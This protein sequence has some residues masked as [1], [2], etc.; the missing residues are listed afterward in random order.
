M[1]SAPVRYEPHEKPPHA[2]AAGLGAQ[3]VVLMVTGVMVTPL[4]IS[5][6]A[7]LDASTTGWLV[8]AALFA[9]G[10]STWLQTSRFGSVGGG[11]AL[12]VG[13]NVAFVSVCTSAIEGGGLPLMATLAMLS[14]FSCFLFTTQMGALRRVLTPAV[15]GMTLM[16]M[17]LSVAPVVWKLLKKVPPEFAD[18]NLP[19]MLAV[20]TLVPIVLI[21]LFAGDLL[22]LWAPLVGVAV[23]SAVAWHL[24]MIDPTAVLAAPWIGMP[25]A[26][27]P[28]LDLSFGPE[29][30]ALLPAFVLISLVGCIE[31]YA[32]GIAV[33]RNSYR[34]VQPI[35]FRRVQGAINADGV[36]SAIA[37]ALGTVPNTVYSMSVGIVDLTRVAARRVGYWGGLFLILLAF[38]PRIGALIG[39]MPSPVAAA[40]ILMILVL[41]FGHG[42]R[43]VTEEPLG[44][45]AGIAVCLGF[46]MGVGFQGGFLFN[47]RLP[48][49]A[50]LFLSNGTTSGGL[51]AIVLMSLM[52]LR[53]RARDRISVPLA[54]DS[55]GPLRGVVQSFCK[56]LG[57]D[58]RAE[59]RVMLA[60]E[61]ALVFLMENH[62]RAGDTG[63]SQL[64]VRFREIDG[65]AEI[66]YISTPANVNMESAL[67]SLPEQQ[68][69]VDLESELS[70][71]LLRGMTRELRHMQYHGV[72]YL[73]IRLDSATR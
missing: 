30:W 25:Q 28:G 8:F 64:H 1:S 66:E 38:S 26:S 53:H 56:R 29:F 69:S 71:R 40:Y 2:L 4:V 62:A 23:G 13:S 39:A 45:E 11:Y 41:L 22:R 31:T 27:W 33:Q 73:M 20:S 54:A 12:F 34:A 67:A 65:E 42:L 61:E 48:E 3:V 49:W 55:L 16:L 58:S 35:D 19:G 43:M 47:E 17:S 5:R 32:D 50:Q 6:A 9:A 60:A 24:G 37:G 21:S 59:N 70:L 36:G 68:D 57:W 18:T 46:W 10:I 14:A 63:A 44:F 72:D 52:S 7:G 15:G 51:T